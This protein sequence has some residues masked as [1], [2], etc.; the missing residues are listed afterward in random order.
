MYEFQFRDR[1]TLRPLMIGLLLCAT[2][3][4]QAEKDRLSG[5]F[6][7][8]LALTY[9]TYVLRSRCSA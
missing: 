5:K 2:A 9:P 4:A 1:L 7:I 8:R 6:E 3:G